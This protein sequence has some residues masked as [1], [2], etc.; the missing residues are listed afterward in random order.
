MGIEDGTPRPGP[1]GRSGATGAG[2]GAMARWG[3]MTSAS[4]ALIRRP[5]PSSQSHERPWTGPWAAHPLAV[6]PDVDNMVTVQEPVVRTGSF[7]GARDEL[8]AMLSGCRRPWVAE[9][10]GTGHGGKSAAGS[11]FRALRAQECEIPMLAAYRNV[12]MD[13]TFHRR[14]GG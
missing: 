6:P 5:L 4:S 13:S 12:P 14:S 2:A 8:L 1:R 10:M 3:L 7:E 11:G 9:V